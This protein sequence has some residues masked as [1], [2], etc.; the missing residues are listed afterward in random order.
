MMHSDLSTINV[1]VM[2]I[3]IRYGEGD[4]GVKLR[5]GVVNKRKRQRRSSKEWE[6]QVSMD[7]SGQRQTDLPESSI[8][9]LAAGLACAISHSHE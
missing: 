8:W 5:C 1:R 7:G 6:L 9:Y 4:I 3:K 2:G